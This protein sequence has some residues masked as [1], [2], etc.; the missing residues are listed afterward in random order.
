MSEP[1]ALRLAYRLEH[2]DKWC[3]SSHANLVGAAAELRRQHSRIA[4]LEAER[5]ADRAAM[6]EA[7]EALTRCVK[8]IDRLAEIARKWKPEISFGADRQRIAQ[9]EY[10]GN[11]ARTAVEKLKARTG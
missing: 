10:A 7:M 9:A 6:R 4:E 5:E 2:D 8:G 11:D 3:L 1:E